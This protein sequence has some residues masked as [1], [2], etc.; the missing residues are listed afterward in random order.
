MNER[1]KDFIRMMN[2]YPQGTNVFGQQIQQP[3]TAKETVNVLKSNLPKMRG[4]VATAIPYI[5]VAG[6]I[7]DIV[8]GGKKVLSPTKEGD[9][10]GGLGQA[11]LGALGLVPGM[12]WARY[13]KA[14]KLAKLPV[15]S[16]IKAVGFPTAGALVGS[17]SNQAKI[18]T[19]PVPLETITEQ[20]GAPVAGSQDMNGVQYTVLPEPPNSNAVANDM[21]QIIGAMG[22]NR[23]VVPT[24]SMQM[25]TTI[26]QQQIQQQ[27][28][29]DS[30]ARALID[31]YNKQYQE[32]QKPQAQA[33]KEYKRKLPYANISDALIR[34]GLASYAQAYDIPGLANAYYGSEYTNRL[35]KNYELDQAIAGMPMNRFN[36]VNTLAGNIAV[37]NQMGMDPAVAMADKDIQKVLTAY[38]QIGGR[39]NVANIN[40]MAKMYGADRGVDVANIKAMAQ[41]LSTD[42]RLSAQE[43]MYYANLANKLDIA[44]M[45]ATVAP[46]RFGYDITPEYVDLIN[47]GASIQSPIVPSTNVLGGMLGNQGFTN[48]LDFNRINRGN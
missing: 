45:N 1:V 6:S 35:A 34:A 24:S 7:Y 42:A 18:N 12:Q 38:N 5:P 36:A 21:A 47:S 8:A 39:E 37:A 17:D 33:L 27:V 41:A 32:M 30:I 40:A 9:L 28:A 19:Q 26:P 43:R 46:Y 44:R 48:Q 31:M 4:A 29:D 2:K 3:Q 11:G 10:W 15:A 13:A 20:A 23:G 14:G 25:Q 16:K 22:G